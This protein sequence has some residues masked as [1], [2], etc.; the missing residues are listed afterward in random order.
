MLWNEKSNRRRWNSHDTEV[1]FTDHFIPRALKY[2]TVES[3]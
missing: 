2:P 3:K 1:F